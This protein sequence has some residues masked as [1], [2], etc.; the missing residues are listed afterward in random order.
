MKIKKVFQWLGKETLSGFLN[1]WIATSAVSG[2]LAIA[3]AIF[4][5]RICNTAIDLWQL[6]ASRWT[7]QEAI[8]VLDIVLMSF[9][10]FFLLGIYLFKKRLTNQQINNEVQASKVDMDKS[11]EREEFRTF[12]GVTFKFRLSDGMLSDD[13]YCPKDHLPFIVHNRRAL[14]RR[15]GI[16]MCKCPMCN[17][18]LEMDEIKLNDIRMRFQLIAESYVI[19]DLKELPTES[20]EHTVEREIKKKETKLTKEQIRLLNHL[21]G[22]EKNILNRYF[23]EDHKTISFPLLFNKDM[24]RAGLIENNILS[25]SSSSIIDMALFPQL[26]KP[27]RLYT[28]NEL[29]WQYLKDNPQ[30]LK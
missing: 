16:I 23:V 13:Y 1:Y 15:E 6:P 3:I 11:R 10:F 12:E 7:W 14:G 21:S 29:A 27:E 18:L 26:V 2:T 17:E 19:G 22:G 20:E 4:W 8:I 30:L 25:D 24:D 5:H 28:I 9:I